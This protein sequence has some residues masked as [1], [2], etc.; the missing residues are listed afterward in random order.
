MLKNKVSYQLRSLVAIVIILLALASIIVFTTNGSV[1]AAQSGTVVTLIPPAQ[2]HPNQLI[3]MTL[4]AQNAQN[5]AGYQAVIHYNA[6]GLR[7]GGFGMEQGLAGSGR[8]ILPL[9]PVQDEGSVIV[10][11]VT[12]PVTNCSTPQYDTAQR[13][14]QGVAGN[15]ELITLE[16]IAE[17]PGLYQF[18]LEDVHL[19]D[20]QG[21]Q[22]GVAI[23]QNSVLEVTAK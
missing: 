18:T 9:S 15:I 12:C 8:G 2:A 19:V 23:Q 5:L 11:A 6:N 13:H 7:I 3:R 14:P 1:S 21:N 16:L 22:L 4:M 10:G 17:A 20:P